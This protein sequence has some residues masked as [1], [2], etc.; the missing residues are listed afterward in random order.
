MAKSKAS[1]SSATRKKHAA[2][3][4]PEAEAAPAPAQRGQKKVKVSR[5]APKIKSYTPPP[6]PPKGAPDP[7]D[8]Y[9]GAGALVDPELVVILRRL[10]K[11]D[12]ATIAKGVD[13]LES[14]VRAALRDEARLSKADDDE[15]WKLEQRRD[16]VVSSMA[17]WVRASS[18]AAPAD[19]V[20][21]PSLSATFAPSL[22][23]TPT[24][25]AHAAYP[26]RR[27]S[28]DRPTLR[29][30]R[31]DPLC[32]AG[33]TMDRAARVCRRLVLQRI[34]SRP[35]RTQRCPKRVGR[36]CAAQSCS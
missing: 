4:A 28:L 11:R 31:P 9:L 12:E 20:A 25:G 7:V 16:E 22:A 34:R 29:A 17:V 23:A 14:W 19:P 35:R 21:G 5:F 2:K 18:V 8:L 32:P 3:H 36:C 33:P 15:P 30:C 24:P 27:P 6:P 10:S 1:A 13:G 26:P